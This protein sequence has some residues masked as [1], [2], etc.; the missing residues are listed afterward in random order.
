MNNRK[1][2]YVMMLLALVCAG[3]GKNQSK[4]VYK[5]FDDTAA[6]SQ[7]TGDTQEEPKEEV[8]VIKEKPKGPTADDII[9]RGKMYIGTPYYYGGISP[10]T[11]FDCSGFVNYVYKRVY[12]ESPLPRSSKDIV[13]LGKYVSK[14]KLQKGDLVFFNTLG[15]PY[16][17]IGIYVGDDKFIHSSTSKGIIISPMNSKY[18]KPKYETARRIDVSKLKKK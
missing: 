15:R 13:K 12:G 1:L 10:K 3:C 18:Y 17:H 5:R 8:A 14:S 4:G 7:K 9:N 6:G 11:G 16:S 2:F